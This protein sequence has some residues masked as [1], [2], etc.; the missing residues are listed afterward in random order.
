[1]VSLRVEDHPNPLPE[2]G[3]LVSLQEAYA[4]A[5]RGDD[6]VSEGRHEAPPPCVPWWAGC[7]IA[8]T[9]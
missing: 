9:V 4:L 6:L 1:M 7:R 8:K 3:R 5:T 2:L